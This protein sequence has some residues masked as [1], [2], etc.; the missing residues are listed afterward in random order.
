[1]GDRATETWAYRL[2][3][4][5]EIVP[6]TDPSRVCP[7]DVLELEILANGEPANGQLVYA[8]YEGFGAALGIEGHREAIKTRADREG[9]ARIE[10]TREGRWYAR[11]IRMIE[12]NEEE[13]DY[14]SNW[15]TLTFEVDCPG[16]D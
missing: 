5:V 8:S 1:M 16:T 14:E 9:V 4:P 3:Y 10:V 2:G 7:G 12:V 15:A 6:L 11:L 13:V